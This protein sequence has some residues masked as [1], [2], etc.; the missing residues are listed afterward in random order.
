[1]LKIYGILLRCAG[2]IINRF[3]GDVLDTSNYPEEDEKNAISE[4]SKR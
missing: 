4:T 1:M 3:F 2:K